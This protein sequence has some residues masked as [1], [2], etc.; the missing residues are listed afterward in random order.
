MK[1]SRT[2]RLSP[3]QLANRAHMLERGEKKHANREERMA[4]PPTEL[5]KPLSDDD[6]TRLQLAAMEKIGPV[7]SQR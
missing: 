3:K 2:K 1:G 5:T 6:K 4:K 7:S